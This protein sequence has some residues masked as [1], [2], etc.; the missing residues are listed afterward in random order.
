MLKIL[1]EVR[2]QFYYLRSY[3]FRELAFCEEF[4]QDYLAAEQ[5]FKLSCNF[6]NEESWQ[7]Q[8]SS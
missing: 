3:C 2:S 6:I 8:Q 7:R 1:D 5:H 4:E